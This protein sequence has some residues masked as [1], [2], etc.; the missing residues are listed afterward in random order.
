M[1]QGM[2]MP[3][4]MLGMTRS[5]LTMMEFNEQK[6]DYLSSLAD[7]E[8]GSQAYQDALEA[9][10]RRGAERC[11]KVAQLHRGLY[12]KA[13][14]FI[15]SLRGGTGDRGV[16]KAYIEEL[17]VFTDHAPHKPLAE[18]ATVLK[19]CMELGDWPEGPLP[20]SAP[21]AEF[22]G[23]P[24]ASAS[25]AQVHHAVLRDGRRVA[26]KIQ[27]PEL[28]KEMASDFHVFKTMGAQ[29]TQMAQGYDVMWIVDDFEKYL[30]RELDFQLEAANAQETARALAHLAPN[31]Y[32]P[33]ILKEFS[34]S[35]VVTM[36]FCEGM[37]KANDTAALTRAGLDPLECA[38]L[39]CSTFAEMIFVHGRVHA[40]PHAGNIYIRPRE[41]R[42][43]RRKPQLV[44][45]DHGL[46]HD[47]NE[48]DV[49]WNFCKYWQACCS[50]NRGQ[51]EEIGQRF[52]GALRRFLPL[53]LSPWFVLSGAGA[54][55][56]DIVCASQGRLP[57]SVGLRDVADFVCATREGGAN[58]IG[59]LHSL[60]Y[61]RGL[62]EAHAYPE[63]RR[64]EVMLKYAM[65]GD[66]KTPPAVPHPLSVTQ[67]LWMS[68]HVTVF[69]SQVYLSAP[70]AGVLLKYVRDRQVPSFWFLVSIPALLA[71]L[72]FGAR[73]ALAIRQ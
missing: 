22:E 26:V 17:S 73:Y 3:D 35:R 47:L 68:W 14:Q 6:Q 25:L 5:M 48:N 36:E 39:I 29:I 64:V 46:Y 37:V 24:I 70:V 21:F 1:A 71:V 41:D 32:V 59:L 33:P 55:L 45:L 40:D 12:V 15:A 54:S 10:H 20:E 63:R 72:G 67:E 66:N 11:R 58:L 9:C 18:I 23:E 69:S 2:A 19:E 16:P 57:D 44:I 60:G 38:N 56:R 50:K 27:Y 8:E 51:M 61:I 7:L 4:M 65:L 53:I 28:Q 31:V 62:L 42:P 34:S 13:A 30:T 49:R 52:A 43:G